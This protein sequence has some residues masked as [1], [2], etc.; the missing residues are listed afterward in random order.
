MRS[1]GCAACHGANGQG[2]VGPAFQGLYGSEVALDDGT[3]V[4]ADDEY[5]RRSIEEPGEQSSR[6]TRCRCRRTTST[7][8]IDEII[9]FIA[10]IGPEA[11][12]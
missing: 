6:G 4:T 3:T 2:G 11:A 8:Q 12:E 10:A 5:L 7:P 1:N 9:G